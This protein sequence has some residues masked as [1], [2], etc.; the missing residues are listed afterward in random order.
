[1]PYP[2]SK[3]VS[4]K[5]KYYVNCTIPPEL[6]PWFSD[7]KQYRLS[8]GTSDRKVA[9]LRQH[10]LTRQI[11]QKFDEATE[12]LKRQRLGEL[13]AEFGQPVEM[14]DLDRI[15][16][17]LVPMSGDM[18]EDLAREAHYRG[19][20][21]KVDDLRALDTSHTIEGLCHAYTASQPYGRNRQKTAKEASTALDEFCQFVGP[22]K[23]AAS[24]KPRDAY[25]YAEAL[26]E[27][28]S[29][30]TIAKKIGYVRQCLNW[31]VR[32]G[33]LELNPFVE[34]SLSK[35]GTKG[36]GWKPFTREE[37]TKLFKLDMEPH[38]RALL[39]ILATTGMRLDEAALLKW[40][41]I[42]LHDGT[43]YFDLTD[44]METVKNIGSARQVPVPAEAYS[45]IVNYKLHHQLGNE[46]S[47]RLFPQYRLNADGKA[48]GPASKALMVLVRQITDDRKK[49]VH[50]LRGSF[51]DML[52]DAGVSKEINDFITG[53]SG[54]DVASGY[55]TGPSLKTKAEA[56][57]LVDFSF[58]NNK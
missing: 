53:H 18:E 57:A 10:D 46:L 1:M 54:N 15:A 33:H 43:R 29:Q 11:Y 34:L 25:R 28:K 39:S 12:G 56:M 3:L 23:D 58:I 41:D 35:Y 30:K 7:R 2:A 20:Q 44:R 48:Q 55:G 27:T 22:T 14:Q 42:K 21:R 32:Q 47:E 9:E 26:S 13:E 51:K 8:T 36:S 38:E 52:R 49:V 4:L 17:P 6:R 50:S 40:D 45:A 31:A 19:L 24:L 5:E 37:L 16:T